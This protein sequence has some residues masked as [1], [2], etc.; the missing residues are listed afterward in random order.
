VARQPRG[1]SGAKTKEKKPAAITLRGGICSKK[2]GFN[3]NMGKNVS[4]G[5][6]AF[7]AV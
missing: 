2:A 7:E 4:V 1:G 6:V 3:I 5:F